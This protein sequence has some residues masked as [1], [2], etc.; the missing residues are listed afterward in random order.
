MHLQAWETL[1]EQIGQLQLLKGIFHGGKKTHQKLADRL[2]TC[3]TDK[4]ECSNH[5]NSPT[6]PWP[7]SIATFPQLQLTYQLRTVSSSQ[8]VHQY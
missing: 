1:T 8:E 2:W 5:S 3:F 6:S 4:V 7:P